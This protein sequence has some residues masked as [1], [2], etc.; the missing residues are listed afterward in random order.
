MTGS[1]T[2]R[3]DPLLQPGL[4]VV[5]VGTS[6]GVE[7]LRTGQDVIGPGPTPVSPTTHPL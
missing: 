6:A 1:R 2:D 4:K 7:S 3:L 5:F